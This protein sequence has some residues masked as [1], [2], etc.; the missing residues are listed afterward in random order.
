VLVTE[1]DRLVDAGSLTSSARPGADFVVWAAVHRLATLLLDGLVHLDTHRDVDREV[2]R[3]VR[4]V[5]N[6]L[7]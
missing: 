7:G 1:L 6:S 2:E 5:V 3:L 4:A